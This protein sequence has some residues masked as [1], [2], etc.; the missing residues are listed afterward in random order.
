M[1][2]RLIISFVG[3]LIDIIATLYLTNLGYMEANFIMARTLQWPLLFIAIKLLAMTLVLVLLWRER[4]DKKAI[5]ASWIACIVYGLIGVY[6]V[7]I[8]RLLI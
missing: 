7:F 8:F 3:N 6:Y 5:F 2:M 1:K 4:H